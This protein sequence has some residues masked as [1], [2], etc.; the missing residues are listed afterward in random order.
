M[1]K[2]LIAL[3]VAVFALV[4]FAVPANAGI[5]Y[6]NDTPGVVTVHEFNT[7]HRGMTRHEVTEHFGTRGHSVGGFW[8]KARF[9]T[10]IQYV[11]T[12]GPVFAVFV[13]PDGTN[14][15]MLLSRVYRFTKNKMCVRYH[16]V[17]LTAF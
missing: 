5:G 13:D 4:S 7:T 8:D 14:N 3:I 1:T 16:C 11:G 12:N 17:P 2:K 9:V 6:W 15:S 10:T